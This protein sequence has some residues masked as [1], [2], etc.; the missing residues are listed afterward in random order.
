MSSKNLIRSL[1]IFSKDVIFYP[2]L[3]AWNPQM[4]RPRDYQWIYHKNLLNWFLITE[5][6]DQLT[7]NILY[8]NFQDQIVL[9]VRPGNNLRK[10]ILGLVCKDISCTISILYKHRLESQLLHFQYS[11]L[12]NWPEKSSRRWPEH[13]GPSCG[14][15]R[16]S[17]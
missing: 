1:H 3:W 9:L 10:I 4:Q 15:L 2:N 7:K 12:L 13:L 8:E 6:I 14:K 11:F 16:R 17:P 5:E